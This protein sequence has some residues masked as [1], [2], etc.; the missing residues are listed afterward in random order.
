MKYRKKPVVIEA[1][2]FQRRNNGPV[3]YPDWF[4]DAVTRNDVVTF[5]TGKWHDPS[6]L[7]TCTIRTLEGVRHASEGDWIIRGVKGELYPCRADIF[8]ATYEV[9]E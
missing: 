6:M 5:N 8:E 4:E 9:A 1:F 7:A 2:Q 3:P